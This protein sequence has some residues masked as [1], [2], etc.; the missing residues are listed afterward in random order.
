MRKMDTYLMGPARYGADRQQRDRSE[1]GKQFPMSKRF[2]AL[3]VCYAHKTCLFIP[4]DNGRIDSTLLTRHY[5]EY[6]GQICLFDK[7]VSEITCKLG[8]C[9]DVLGENHNTGGGFI[10]AVYQPKFAAELPP[11][12]LT[13]DIGKFS[14]TGAVSGYRDSARFIDND[15][16]II[17]I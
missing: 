3:L 8:L 1:I 2:F 9:L 14:S 17:L 10:Q 15:N 7:L 4:L 5:A 6:K 13:E 16:I 11:Q 12:L